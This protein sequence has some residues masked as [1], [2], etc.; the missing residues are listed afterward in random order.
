MS[1]QTRENK[2]F[3]NLKGSAHAKGN[4]R[5]SVGVIVV[6]DLKAM[7]NMPPED[8]VDFLQKRHPELSVREII[9][10]LFQCDSLMLQQS[11]VVWTRR[12]TYAGWGLVIATLALFAATLRLAIVTG[13]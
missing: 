3:V 2:R 4:A 8:R 9:D 12:F 13:R 5:G 6:E 11:L 10:L 7:R 1:E